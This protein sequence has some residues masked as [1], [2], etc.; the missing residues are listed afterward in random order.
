[1]ARDLP[2][3][4]RITGLDYIFTDKS[5]TLEQFVDAAYKA[6]KLRDMDF[7]KTLFL[8]KPAE[9]TALND[10]FLKMSEAVFPMSEEIAKTNESFAANVTALRKDYLV[11]LYDWKGKGLYPDA[12]GTIRFTW[13]PVKGYKPADAV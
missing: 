7:A 5:Q 8:K 10:P 11:A 3:G 9:L 13:G 6:T 4:Q 1:M 2:A 12:N